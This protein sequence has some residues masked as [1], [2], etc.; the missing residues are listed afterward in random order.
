VNMVFINIVM[1]L[2]NRIVNPIHYH[3]HHQHQHQQ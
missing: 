3:R 1:I 2:H